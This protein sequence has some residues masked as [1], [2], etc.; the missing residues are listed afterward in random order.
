MGVLLSMFGRFGTLIV[1]YARGIF[2]TV[3]TGNLL[4]WTL[5]AAVPVAY[6]AIWV[7][8][9]TYGF[10]ALIQWFIGAAPDIFGGSSFPSGAM[11]LL[12]QTFPL[13]L[14]FSTTVSLLVFRVTAAYLVASAVT[15]SRFLKGK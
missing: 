10:S 9:L 8:A 6:V 15:A 3:G 7:T 1:K 12:N 4:G 13:S 2:N 14:M 5:A 11:W